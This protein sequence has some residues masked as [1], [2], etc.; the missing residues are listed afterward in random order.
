MRC[1]VFRF[2]CC[3][4][5]LSWAVVDS[6]VA[7]FLARVDGPCSKPYDPG[8]VLVN[9]RVELLRTGEEDF[10]AQRILDPSDPAG[11][12]LTQS[13]GTE[14]RARKI[15]PG[16]AFLMSAAVPGA[17]QLAEGRRRAFLYFSVEALAWISHFAWKD[18][19][20]K[21][22]GEYEAFARRH[23]DLDD[24]RGVAYGDDPD[25]LDAVPPGVDPA[26]AESTLVRFLRDG[27]LQHYYEDVGKLEAYRAGWD[28]Y[29]CS[30]PNA[31]SPSRREYREMRADSND[32]LE[33]ARFATTMA[34]LNRI[35]SAVDAFRTSKGARMSLDS[36]TS[37]ELGVSGSFS[38]P[39]ASLQV[40][41]IW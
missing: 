22:E 24:W 33:R 40:R 32:Y 39:R 21:K 4:F 5:L 12:V 13:P 3:L 19:G 9:Y 30:N 10:L 1:F 38:R 35:V 16:L 34:F 15:P 18:A 31:M 7:G 29:D 27:N 23:W 11:Q 17:G 6:S 2:F 14:D 36:K 8:C 20:E 28:D 41:R 26:D 37:L 25:C